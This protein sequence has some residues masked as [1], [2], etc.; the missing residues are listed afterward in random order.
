MNNNRS[1]PQGLQTSPEPGLDDAGAYAR[2]VPVLPCESLDE[3]LTFY[4]ALGF[5]VTYEQTTPY[6]YGAVRWGG[7]DLNFYGG[8][9]VNL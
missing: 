9:K 2:V 5:E 4:R 7:V 1:T 3:S 6:V 8:F